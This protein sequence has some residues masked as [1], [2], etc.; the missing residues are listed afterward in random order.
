[1]YRRKRRQAIVLVSASSEESTTNQPANHV[2]RRIVLT[3]LQPVIVE[4][5]ES[6]LKCTVHA[7]TFFNPLM[8]TLKPQSNGPLYINTVIGTLADDG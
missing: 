2:I 8:D 3:M 6:R 1:M 4:L 5:N 7:V